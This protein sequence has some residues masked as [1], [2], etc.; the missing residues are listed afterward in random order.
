LHTIGGS[1][2]QY[3]S[4]VPS[5]DTSCSRTPTVGAPGRGALRVTFYSTKS[6]IAGNDINFA[7][8]SHIW[9]GSLEFVIVG[10][11]YDLDL[12]P[13]TGE[14]ASFS[15]P[16]ANLRQNTQKLYQEPVD[17]DWDG[18]HI[19]SQVSEAHRGN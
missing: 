8:G 11:G 1:D 9:F 18:P 15:K 19:S 17:G 14:P 7:S 12:L 13:P 6:P 10:E 2:A 16:A 5:L 4:L 3:H